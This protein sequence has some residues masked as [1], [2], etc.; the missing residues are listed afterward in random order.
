VK[1]NFERGWHRILIILSVVWGGF[2]FI[3]TAEH[4]QGF[5]PILFISAAIWIIGLLVFHLC[6]KL[7]GWVIAGFREED[8]KTEDDEQDI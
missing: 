6:S 3:L 1:I 4:N 2:C 7:T 8:D 5:Y